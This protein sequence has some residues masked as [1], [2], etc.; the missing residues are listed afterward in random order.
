ME[1]GKTRYS[2]ESGQMKLSLIYNMPTFKNI[3][4]LFAAMGLFC[5]E[6]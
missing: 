1:T 4:L 6:C 2:A 3:A 5:G